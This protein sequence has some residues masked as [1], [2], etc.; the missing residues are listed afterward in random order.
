MFMRELHYKT[1]EPLAGAT[2]PL[3]ERL[4]R[5]IWT[6]FYTAPLV[7]D[8]MLGSALGACARYQSINSIWIL[9]GLAE[10][11]QQDMMASAIARPNP[12]C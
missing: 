4:M 10:S 7:L 3:Q 5:D 8:F 6:G 12:Y 11:C 1:P 2:L 9:V